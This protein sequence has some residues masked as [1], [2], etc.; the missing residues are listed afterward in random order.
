MCDAARA[1]T[2]VEGVRV[3]P[4]H[5]PSRAW[6]GSLTDGRVGPRP[7][8]SLCS[9]RDVSPA[10]RRGLSPAEIAIPLGA[11]PQKVG[12]APIPR[13][14]VAN[15]YVNV[16]NR[17]SERRCPPRQRAITVFVVPIPTRIGAYAL[18]RFLEI[19]VFALAL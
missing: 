3:P 14:A 19:S 10:Y 8:T 15:S 2:A 12:H 4:P 1:A 9:A 6:V 5:N 16:E 11:W 18:R 7:G 17:Y 13:G